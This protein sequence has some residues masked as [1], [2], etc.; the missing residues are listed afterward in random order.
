MAFPVRLRPG[1]PQVRRTWRHLELQ[2]RSGVTQTRMLRWCPHWLA[3]GYT[4]TMLA[5][6]LLRPRPAAIGIVGL[7][8]GAQAR[9]CHRHLPGSRIEAVESD[10]G[11][12]ALRDTFRV[13]ADDA[14]FSV[15]LGDGA[16]WL[17]PRAG[18][19]DILLV[20]AYDVDGIPPALSALAFHRDCA[21]ALAPGG[22]L[23]TN[24][25]ATDARSHVGRM[26]HA[27]DGRVGVLDEPGMDN[28]VAFAWRDPLPALDVDA[29]LRA[30]PWLARL[31]LAAPFRRLAERLGTAPAMR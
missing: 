5:T 12:L 28:R 25:Y 6:L 2:F 3:A 17:L 29:A 11:V 20:D 14:R 24:L 1:T 8:G 30:L 31:Q 27:F 10:A 21:A 13:P 7:G 16:H 15:E 4:R 22:V 9:F 19:Y 18:R 26:R 23:A